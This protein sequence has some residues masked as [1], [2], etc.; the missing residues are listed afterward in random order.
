MSELEDLRKRIDDVDAGMTALF[1]QRMELA[2]EV[3]DYKRANALPVLDRA[4]E[5]AK[6]ASVAEQVPPELHDQVQVLYSL[7]MDMSKAAE[8]RR[9]GTDGTL[10]AL[11]SAASGRTP[12]LFPQDAF[13]ACQGVEGAYSQIAA[14]KLFRH[15]SISFFDTFE[16]VF[17]A[18][19]EGFSSYGVLPVENS[20]AG[21]VNQVYD[22]MMRHDFH[23]VRTVRLKVD[24]SLLAK[25]GTGLADVRDV[26]SHE[27]AIEQC[28]AFLDAHP[29]M[30][31]HVVEN[32]A[33]AAKM[34]SESGRADVAALSSRTCAELYG[35]ETLERSVQ[36]TGN[37]YTRFACISKG[38][39]IY[40]GADRTSLMMIVSHEPGSLYKV[41]AR[42][43]AL[44][45]NLVKLESRPLP[46]RDF[47]FMFYFDLECPVA[48]PAFRDLV[49]SLGEVCEEFRY[50]GS[51]S[52]QV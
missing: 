9:L 2:A 51:Y 41:L 29:E 46:D 8:R 19:D 11:I 45:I 26:Y 20:T 37:N 5:R 33:V 25:R 4:R 52:E 3:A 38:L 30:R 35:L 24:H 12:A 23:I 13:V 15:P 40:P 32:T 18:V 28:S 42:F 21:T 17:R 7:V 1:A 47:E 16:G 27:Q 31:V 44:D 43:Y 6:L 36:D 48:A 10:E 14:D 34:V 22:L 50:L 49:V 39:E